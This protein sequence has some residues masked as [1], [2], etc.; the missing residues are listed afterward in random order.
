MKRFWIAAAAAL[1]ASACAT[2]GCSSMFPHTNKIEEISPSLF[3]Y[4][5]VGQREPL[6]S[7]I[8]VPTAGLREKRHSLTVEGSMMKQMRER[9]NNRHT[10]EI[11]SGKIKMVF[12]SERLA[13]RG[14]FPVLNALMTD[15]D[16]SDRLYL[17]VLRGEMDEK[18]KRGIAE[19]EAFDF[20]LYRMFRHY[21]RRGGIAVTDLHAFMS[22]Y[23]NGYGDPTA[24]VFHLE[25]N[26]FVYEGIG[27]F[28][29]DRLVLVLNGEQNGLFELIRRNRN[30]QATLPLADMRVVLSSVRSNRNVQISE[31][32][33][34]ELSLRMTA[35][36]E[37]YQGTLD[38]GNRRDAFR[39]REAIA[40]R[41]EQQ[42]QGVL[43]RLQAAE[44]DPAAFGMLT[45]GPMHPSPWPRDRWQQIWSKMPVS[46]R[47]VIQL[48]NLGTVFPRRPDGSA[49]ESPPP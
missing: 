28:R 4:F 39:L 16:V 25:Q 34:L 18:T 42:I 33:G 31:K 7:T 46:V 49:S 9:L 36:I 48:T 21:D 19:Q 37:E 44:S 41:L 29:R 24:P 20:Y 11:R 13:R 2:T 12:V 47:C 8:F 17:A 40:R 15:E 10:R 45:F 14:L 23:F 32:G 5:D 22:R 27:A 1:V 6:S 43:E 35:R 30:F 38:L 26:R 3:V